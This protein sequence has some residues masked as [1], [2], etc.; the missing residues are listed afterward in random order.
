MVPAAL[1]SSVR[2]PWVGIGNDSII[3]LFKG[4][5]YLIWATGPEDVTPSAAYPPNVPF[6][7]PFAIDTPD[8]YTYSTRI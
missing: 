8:G 5:R 7:L 3:A 1:P 4:L 2:A 6:L